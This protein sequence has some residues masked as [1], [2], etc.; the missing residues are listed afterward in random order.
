LDLLQESGLITYAG[1]NRIKPSMFMCMMLYRL[2][3]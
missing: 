3:L 1:L 2:E